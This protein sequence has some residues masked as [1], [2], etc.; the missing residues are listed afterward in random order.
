LNLLV[1]IKNR[2]LKTSSVG[3]REEGLREAGPWPPEKK[4][5]GLLST[6]A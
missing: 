2:L 1:E 5:T 4:D 3:D 6:V